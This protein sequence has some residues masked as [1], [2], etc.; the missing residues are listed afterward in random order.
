MIWKAIGMLITVFL[1]PVVLIGGIWTALIFGP[2]AICGLFAYGFIMYCNRERIY[3]Y[4]KEIEA[5][6]PIMMTYHGKRVP[7]R[8]FVYSVISSFVMAPILIVAFFLWVPWV[9]SIP[10]IFLTLGVEIGRWY[11]VK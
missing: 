11:G 9:I 1:F 8:R 6:K 3:K 7:V 5:R 4:R 2:L 10:L